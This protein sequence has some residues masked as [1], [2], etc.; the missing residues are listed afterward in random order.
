MMH[1]CESNKNTGTDGQRSV[2]VAV[3]R[4]LSQL[5]FAQSPVHGNAGEQ[6]VALLLGCHLPP[7]R[8]RRVAAGRPVV[9]RAVRGG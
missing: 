4:G 3:R 5:A 7:H 6:G 2:H 8:W 1:T 9:R